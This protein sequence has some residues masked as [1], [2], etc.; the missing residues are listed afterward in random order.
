MRYPNLTPSALFLICTTV[1]IFISY[2][3]PWHLTLYL[4]SEVIQST[5]LVL[6]CV[7]FILNTLAY[8][9]F[10]KHHTPHA[11]FSTPTTLIDSG[12][13]TLSRNPVYLALVLSLCGLGFIFDTVW[14]LLSALVLLIAIHFLIIPDEE[15]IMERTFNESYGDYKKLTRR[16]L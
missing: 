6:L 4:D 7:S 9:I 5:G 2:M 1:G 16:W 13:F 12:I 10:T 14:L 11:P 15:K 3:Y 8:R